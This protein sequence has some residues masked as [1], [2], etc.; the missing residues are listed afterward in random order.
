MTPAS[1]H[2]SRSLANPLPHAIPSSGTRLDHTRMHHLSEGSQRHNLHDLIRDAS[3]TAT[4][5]RTDAAAGAGDRP[6]PVLTGERVFYPL[7]KIGSLSPK[8][9]AIQNYFKDPTKKNAQALSELLFRECREKH[10]ELPPLFV[11]NLGHTD[12]AKASLQDHIE[13]VLADLADSTESSQTERKKTLQAIKILLEKAFTKEYIILSVTNDKHRI[14]AFAI[15]HKSFL[16]VTTSSG[17]KC[18]SFLALS[19]LDYEDY[20][21]RFSFNPLLASLLEVCF[22]LSFEPSFKG[23]FCI[24]DPIPFAPFGITHSTQH[25]VLEFLDQFGGY[26]KYVDERPAISPPPN[27]GHP[28]DFPGSGSARSHYSTTHSFQLPPSHET[29]H[30]SAVENPSC[31]IVM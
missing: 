11:K 23:R 30:G 9:A 22:L 17:E 5:P 4:P 10:P 1:S 14:L 20:P 8:I 21:S 7:P 19:Y 24:Q 28:M 27:L 6:P 18:K 13:K 2:S 25:L 12:T 3:M 16:P 26:A 29:S 31:C 15:L